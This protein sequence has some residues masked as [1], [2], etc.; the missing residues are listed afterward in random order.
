M[1]RNISSINQ[2]VVFY[3]NT[4]RHIV[5]AIRINGDAAQPIR[6]DE[7]AQA[8]ARALSSLLAKQASSGSFSPPIRKANQVVWVR[9]GAQHTVTV[10]PAMRDSK[11]VEWHVTENKHGLTGK[12]VYVNDRGFRATRS[13]AANGR[14]YYEVHAQNDDYV[15]MF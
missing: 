12:R 3:T 9:A 4:G 14:Y 7:A 1:T 11:P 5:N 10:A 6:K 13:R 15:P 2:V 8:Q